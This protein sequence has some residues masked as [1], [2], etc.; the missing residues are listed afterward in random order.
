MQN[1]NKTAIAPAGECLPYEAEIAPDSLARAYVPYQKIC[2]YF[3]PSKGLVN[4]T[5][6][7]GLYKPYRCKEA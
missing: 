4:G 3:S 7:P 5:I 2:S 6:F 1:D